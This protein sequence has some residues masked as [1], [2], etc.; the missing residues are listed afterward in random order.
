M[1]V[2]GVLEA[3]HLEACAAG[4]VKELVREVAEDSYHEAVLAAR[5]HRSEQVCV[6]VCGAS[7]SYVC[8]SARLTYVRTLYYI[9][10]SLPPSPTHAWLLHTHTHVAGSIICV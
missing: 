6:S 8:L 2:N 7:F 5:A 3:E 4:L 9:H 1:Q 10:A